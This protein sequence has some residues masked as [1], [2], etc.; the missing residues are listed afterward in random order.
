[1]ATPTAAQIAYFR[2]MTGDD[3]NADELVSDA[4]IATHFTN[5]DSD[6]NL[7]I[8][9]M[10]RHM[11]AKT[12]RRTDVRGEFGTD[13]LS[14]WHTNIRDKLLPMWEGIAGVVGGAGL[15]VGEMG[16]GLDMTEDDLE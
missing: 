5:A 1:M 3:N 8:V 9:Y 4:H 6:E 2:A 16:F 10:L 12:A 11:L 7:T 13:R 14:Q 15:S